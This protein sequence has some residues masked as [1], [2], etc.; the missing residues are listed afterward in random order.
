MHRLAALTVV[1]AAVLAAPWTVTAQDHGGWHLLDVPGGRATLRALG[2]NEAGPRA[3]V[4]TEL[5]RRLHFS[6]AT[7]TD[8]EA[9]IRKLPVSGGDVVTLP[10][11]LPPAVWS[12]ILGSAA[13]PP[14]LFAAI[15]ADPQA[16]LLFHGL[17]GLDRP[18]RDWFERQ[19]ELLRRLYRNPDAVKSFALFAPAI[20][21]VAGR[22]EVPGPPIATERWAGV[23]GA[24]PDQ[25]ARFVQRLFEDR[26]G[27][28][29]GLYSTIAF[30]TAPRQAFLLGSG[31]AKFA[32]L[33]AGFADCY[34]ADANDY[35]L[36]IRS[37]DAALLLME[38]GLDHAGVPAGPRSQ[39]FW[40]G[41]FDADDLAQS[42]PQ[43]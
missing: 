24:G 7:Q 36:A 18:T 3:L 22:V 16:R 40:N 17:S 41:V 27:R 42:P 39:T 25:P 43:R 4:L 14:R 31:A 29:A 38:I 8:L 6:T 19:P 13:P 35:P 34:P 32:R 21:V 5:I 28:T 15:L 23:L 2:V 37:N 33:V 20:R 1:A 11:P 30:S 26:R 12:Q 9:A 10:S